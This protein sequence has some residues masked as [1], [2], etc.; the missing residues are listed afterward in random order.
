MSPS[1]LASSPSRRPSLRSGQASRRTEYISTPRFH[2]SSRSDDLSRRIPRALKG[3]LGHVARPEGRREPFRAR[4][5]AEPAPFAALRAG[6]QRTSQDLETRIFPWE[7]ATRTASNSAGG[8]VTS[9]CGSHMI[10]LTAS[11]ARPFL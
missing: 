1:G 10:L 4:R 7:F 9:T 11:L 2:L 8:P 3:R 6:F 5:F